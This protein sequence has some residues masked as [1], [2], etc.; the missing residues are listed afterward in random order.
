[1]SNFYSDY[2]QSG[3]NSTCYDNAHTVTSLADIFSAIAAN[4]TNPRLIP[5]NSQ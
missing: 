3:S 5:N 4:F 2:A 1:L